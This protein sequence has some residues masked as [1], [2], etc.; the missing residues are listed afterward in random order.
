MA[1]CLLRAGFNW[2]VS[3]GFGFGFGFCHHR[4]LQHRQDLDFL[5][6]IGFG[7]GFGFLDIEKNYWFFIGFW[8]SIVVIIITDFLHKDGPN[9]NPVQ[10]QDCSFFGVL[11]L[12]LV[13]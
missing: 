6:L 11:I 13:A 5:V 3:I 2:L 7:F 9:Q 10:E 1:C 8:I 12:P 4:F